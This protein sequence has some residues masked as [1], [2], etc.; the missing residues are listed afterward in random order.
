[1]GVGAGVGETIAEDKPQIGR[2]VLLKKINSNACIFLLKKLNLTEQ[3][4]SECAPR[5]LKVE[6]YRGEEERETETSIS[7]QI[8]ADIMKEQIFRSRIGSWFP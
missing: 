2:L 6:M 3:A 4:K 5:I 1:M 8:K 7:V